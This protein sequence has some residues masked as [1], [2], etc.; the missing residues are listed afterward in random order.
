MPTEDGFF[1]GPTRYPHGYLDTAD[2][3][4]VDGTAVINGSGEFAGATNGTTG[5]FSSTLSATGNLNIGSGTFF[6]DVSNDY[7]GVNTSSPDYSFVVAATSTGNNLFYVETDGDAVLGAFDFTV[8]TDTFFVDASEDSVAVNTTTLTGAFDVA[9]S[10]GALMFYVQ[11]DGDVLVG[12]SNEFFIDV[13]DNGFSVNTSTLNS[14]E[15]NVYSTGTTTA[16][17]LGGG[18]RGTCHSESIDDGTTLYWW[19]TG[20]GTIAT[21]TASCK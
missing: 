8:D 12:S 2:G 10:T 4:Y 21:S 17:L 11:R 19:W 14:S 16:Q 1:G 15:L 18:G 5:A 20:T 9:T 3:Y 6:V 13:T 7:V